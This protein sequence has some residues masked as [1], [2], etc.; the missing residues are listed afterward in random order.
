[1]PRSGARANP[2]IEAL[3]ADAGPC[4][5][6]SRPTH[7]SGSPDRPAI[8]DREGARAAGR[9]VHARVQRARCLPLGFGARRFRRTAGRARYARLA[10]VAE[11]R[12]AAGARGAADGVQSTRRARARSSSGSISISRRPRATA[13]WRPAV[14]EYYTALSLLART[15][16]GAIAPKRCAFSSS[17]SGARICPA[18]CRG[19]PGARSASD[20]SPT[21]RRTSKALFGWILDRRQ[22]ADARGFSIASLDIVSRMAELQKAHRDA[23]PRRLAY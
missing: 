12:V 18:K 17:I 10:D 23:R 7:S 4:R 19:R 2:A 11:P 3:I 6:N 22:P 14:D 1:M 13:R 8:G 5:R 20:R 16:F 9:S 21:K 15:T